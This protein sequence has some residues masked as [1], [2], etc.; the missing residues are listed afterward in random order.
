[1]GGTKQVLSKIVRSS[2]LVT[3]PAKGAA[4]GA[5]RDNMAHLWGSLMWARCI[6]QSS[7]L[8]TTSKGDPKYPLL[9][10]Q[11]CGVSHPLWCQM[12]PVF[13]MMSLGCETPTPLGVR[14]T[15]AQSST[16]A[17]IF[18]GQWKATPAI[19]QEETVV[20]ITLLIKSQL[21]WMVQYISCLIY[22]SSIFTDFSQH[23]VSYVFKFS[24]SMMKNWTFHLLK[25]IISSPEAEISISSQELGSWHRW[26][27]SIF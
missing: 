27:M 1:M 11:W 5:P 17:A 20:E 25:E 9:A 12:F 18:I 7:S 22:C 24:L 26:I 21:R 16:P 13:G 3:S 23:L 8:K 2:Y 10:I 14:E 15:P 6:L 4:I 19:N